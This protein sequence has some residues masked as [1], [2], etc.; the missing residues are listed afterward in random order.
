VPKDAFADIAQLQEARE[1]L[2]QKIK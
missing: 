1:M 2:K